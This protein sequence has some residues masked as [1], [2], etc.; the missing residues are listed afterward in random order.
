M[1]LKSLPMTLHCISERISLLQLKQ[2]LSFCLR[3]STQF[4]KHVSDKSWTWNSLFWL[5]MT[6]DWL[7][8]VSSTQSFS[9]RCLIRFLFLSWERHRSARTHGSWRTGAVQSICEASLRWLHQAHHET[10]RSHYTFQPEKW[11]RCRHAHLESQDQNEAHRAAQSWH[12][13]GPWPSR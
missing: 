8:E 2:L 11:Q 1:T 6:Y 13:E 7:V 12:F 4:K 10:C 5:Q 3:G 9:H